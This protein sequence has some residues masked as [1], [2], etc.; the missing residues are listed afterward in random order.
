MHMIKI[1][2]SQGSSLPPKDEAVHNIDSSERSSRIIQIVLAIYLLPALALVLLVGF[3]MLLFGAVIQGTLRVRSA[4]ISPR[5]HDFSSE[6]WI[7]RVSGD[8][9]PRR[10]RIRAHATAS[11][12]WPCR[13]DSDILN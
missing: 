5:P 8:A 1:I 10:L 7:Y 4:L 9:V 13:A 3:T 2:E 11:G 12:G 6:P